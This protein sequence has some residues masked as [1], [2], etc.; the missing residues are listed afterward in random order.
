VIVGIDGSNLRTGG[1]T[2][3]IRNLLSVAEPGRFGIEQVVLWTSEATL[4]LLPERDW[5]EAVHEPWLDRSL[6]WRLAW[7]WFRLPRL[8]ERRCDVL[9]SPGG[10]ARPGAVPIVTMSRNMLPFELGELFR[11]RI[12]WMT[13]RLLLLR[14]GQSRTFRRADGLIFLTDY[15]RE[16][17]QRVARA[18][19]RTAVIPH[20]V[21]ERFRGEPRPQRPL[22]ACS[23]EQPLRLLYVSIVDVYK[24]QWQVAEAVASLRREGLPV[25]IDFVGPAYP[26]AE[27]RL[28]ASLERLDPAGEFLRY[29]GPMPFEALHELQQT[30]EIFVFASSCE[31]MPNILLE[32]M[33]SG[34]PIACARRGPMPEILG[35]AGAWFDPERPQE[36]AAAIRSLAEDPERRGRCAR[37]AYEA[38]RAYSWDRCAR[39]SLE[40]I[41]AVVDD[42]LAGRR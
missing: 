35:D 4:G 34:Y 38:A 27:R 15:A 6:P 9:F 28:R 42:A 3:H 17:V 2:T 18:G 41:G 13:L 21:E 20:G 29:R 26:P 39:E 31:N 5:L 40:F 37:A 16:A 24:H 25:A 22:S 11:Y 1:G 14:F 36:I 32:A 10:N 23:P 19:G 7:Q 12:S 8:V 33:A 30:A